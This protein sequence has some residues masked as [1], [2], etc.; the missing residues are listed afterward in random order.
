MRPEQP[1][2]GNQ[3]TYQQVCKTRKTQRRG[4]LTRLLR[5]VALKEGGGLRLSETDY[6]IGFEGG[7]LRA[8]LRQQRVKETQKQGKNEAA[9]PPGLEAPA[10]DEDD[11][12]PCEPKGFGV[13]VVA[14]NGYFQSF[15]EGRG[16]F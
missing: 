10:T 9:S 16:Q 12:N 6:N 2:S 5:A 8:L 1:S 15:A 14:V 11:E 13:D 7:T 4:A 3:Q